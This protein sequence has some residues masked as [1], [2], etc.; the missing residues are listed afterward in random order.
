MMDA[1]R[2]YCGIEAVS[3]YF[4]RSSGQLQREKRNQM[5]TNSPIPLVDT[6]SGEQRTGK[7]V[8]NHGAEL[9]YM[10]VFLSGVP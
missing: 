3:L 9:R 2:R 10:R 1:G 4:V 7:R 8:W 5:H 6:N